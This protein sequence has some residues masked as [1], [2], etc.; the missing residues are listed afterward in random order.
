MTLAS[1]QLEDF[2]V[3]SF[4]KVVSTAGNSV[5]YNYCSADDISSRPSASDLAMSLIVVWQRL[6]IK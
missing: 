4:S 2:H 3:P 1:V 5:L 6:V